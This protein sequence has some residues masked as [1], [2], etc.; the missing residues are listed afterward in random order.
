MQV[1]FSLPLLLCHV[2]VVTGVAGCHGDRDKD[3]R[4][5]Q[6]CTAGGFSDIPSGL[7][8]TTEVLL[9]PVNQ[10]SSLSWSNYKMFP[11]IYEIDLT[12]NKIHALLAGSAG[13]LLLSL[14]VL[15]LGSND[16]EILRDGSF[17]PCPSLTELYLPHNALTSLPDNIFAGLSKLEILD[18]SSNKITVLPPNL[19]QPLVAIEALFMEYNKIQVMPDDWFSVK[20]IPYL[21]LSANPWLCSCSLGYL[22]GYLNDY[23]T[24]VYVRDGAFINGDAESVVGI[25]HSYRLWESTGGSYWL[26]EPRSDTFG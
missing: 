13:V 18:L 17:S 23:E 24:N 15:R 26:I 9:L 21:F 16:M 7:D 25:L 10:L 6:N 14:R 11:D 5:R 4:P 8:P 19:I 22:N 2:T 1:F 12:T 20:D 3:N